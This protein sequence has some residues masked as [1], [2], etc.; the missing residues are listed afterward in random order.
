MTEVIISALINIYNWFGSLTKSDWILLL[1]FFAIVI[2][3]RETFKLRKWQQKSV[4][5]S[6]LDL[7]QR[8]LIHQ[9]TMRSQNKNVDMNINNE[10]IANIMN[11]ILKRVKFDFKKLY[12]RGVIQSHS[13]KNLLTKLK[14]K[15][16]DFL[17]I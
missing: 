11:D 16:W 9:D 3:T 17:K 10:K 4:Q 13:N 6:I 15:I 2:Y 5:I 1:T 8:I 14:I 12:A 7:R